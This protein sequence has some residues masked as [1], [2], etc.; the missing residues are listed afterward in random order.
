[1]EVTQ[2]LVV[3]GA[4]LAGLAFMFVTRML[5]TILRH[6][7]QLAVVAVA[8]VVLSQNGYIDTEALRQSKFAAALSRGY[9]WVSTGATVAGSWIQSYD[10][11]VKVVPAVHSE[12]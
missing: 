2:P 6:S 3:L 1:M 7:F 4:F 10:L 12:N 5:W 8:F 9:D 11:Q